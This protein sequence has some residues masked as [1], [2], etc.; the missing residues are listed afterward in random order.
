MADVGS[1]NDNQ[2][3]QIKSIRGTCQVICFSPIHNKTVAEFSVSEILEVINTWKKTFISL[4][5]LEFVNHVLIF[6][7]KG[8]SMGCSNPHPHGQVFIYLQQVW[9][10]EHVPEEPQKEIDNMI[11]YKEKNNTCMLCDYV[12]MEQ[13]KRDRIVCE[14]E[15]FLVVVPYW[16]IWPYETMVLPKK[17][18]DKL[19]LLS[20]KEDLDLADIIRY[21]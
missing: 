12:K 6:E 5:N 19:T 16:A 15:S 8:A 20:D 17:H 11:K 13:E 18:I 21:T 2:L 1:S 3:F 14:N 10:T 7:N 9:A 4:S